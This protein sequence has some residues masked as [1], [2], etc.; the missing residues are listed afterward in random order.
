MGTLK[1]AT[2]EALKERLGGAVYCWSHPAFNTVHTHIYT[3]TPSNTTP[4]PLR[5]PSQALT[6][7]VPIPASPS[8]PPSS[9]SS[10]S[11]SQPLL[12]GLRRSLLHPKPLLQGLRCRHLQRPHPSLSFRIVVVDRCL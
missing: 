4:V 9:P 6:L 10:V 7:S 12:Q 1:V 2:T 11:P 5:T 3:H 8:G